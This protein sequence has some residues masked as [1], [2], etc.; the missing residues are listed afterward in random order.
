MSSATTTLPPLAVAIQH[1]Q[2]NLEAQLG[3]LRFGCEISRTYNPRTGEVD[4]SF[5]WKSM[6]DREENVTR[7]LRELHGLLI[8]AGF[9]VAYVGVPARL[10]LKSYYGRPIHAPSDAAPAPAAPLAKIYDLATERAR[11]AS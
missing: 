1:H 4:L 9:V 7:A 8:T 5:T 10:R 6:E 3:R 11:R 2:P